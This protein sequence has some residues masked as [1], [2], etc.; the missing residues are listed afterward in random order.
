[1][2]PFASALKLEVPEA[3]LRQ[4][5]SPLPMDKDRF[6]S[7]GI[8]ATRPS[9]VAACQLILHDIGTS[10]D[11]P[12]RN[13]AIRDAY[14][15][16]DELN[17]IGNIGEV[18]SDSPFEQSLGSNHDGIVK[19]KQITVVVFF[20]K[21][22]EPLVEIEEHTVVRR[23]QLDARM[24]GANVAS[25]SL[26]YHNGLPTVLIQKLKQHIAIGIIEVLP[27]IG[28]REREST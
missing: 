16:H 27:R 10:K 2:G 8:L 14:L 21:P 24:R 7:V 20:R 11:M 17:T 15:V 12:C 13:R 4:C 18:L 23:D 19:L 25:E 1:M 22:Q 3:H 5:L 26:V 9:G 6:G 28:A